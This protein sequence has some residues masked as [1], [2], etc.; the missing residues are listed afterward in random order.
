MP[1][2]RLLQ[3]LLTATLLVSSSLVQAQDMNLLP[4]YGSQP[5]NDAL[6][7][8]DAIF[9]SGMDE[10]YHG[11]RAKASMDMAMRGWQYLA[12]GDFDT[13]MRRFNLAWLLN[14]SNGTALW[15]MGAYE[16]HSGKLDES[17]KLFAEAEPLVGDQINFSVDY[18]KAMGKA[19]VT[20][21][22]D[23]LLKDAF[24]RFARIYQRVPDNVLNLQNWAMTLYSMG[25]Y[26][27]AWAKVN[28]PKPRQ[29]KINSTPV[30]S[31]IS[32]PTCPARKTNRIQAGWP[33]S[34]IWAPQLRDGFIV[35]KVGY[36]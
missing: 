21:K 23:A 2:K 33:T 14:N 35:S 7:A 8:S 31:R 29:K 17:L 4:K 34:Q 24:A 12:A 9:I 20:L 1:A 11:D 25:N 18:A 19:G 3:N 13:A 5:K 26:S 10:E 6:K 22:D 27:E 32:N 15:G 16:A 30:S 28:S 36:C